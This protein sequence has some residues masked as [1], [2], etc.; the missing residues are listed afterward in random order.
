MRMPGTFYAF[1]ASDTVEAQSTDNQLIDAALAGDSRAF[2]Q[3]VQRYQ[4]RLLHTLAQM[5]DCEDDACD[6][7]QETFIQAYVKLASFERKSGFYTW[8]YRIGM[9]LAVSRRRRNRPVLSIDRMREES[10]IEPPDQG[11]APHARLDRQEAVDQVQAAIARLPDEFR[12]AL[13]LREIEG[14]DY[15]TI[16]EMLDIPVGTVRSRLHRARVQVRELLSTPAPLKA[17][18]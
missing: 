7:A 1:G 10:D 14:F 8:L 12:M 15:D 6:V 13:I 2:G 4:D 5:L 17:E 3:L 16:A 9:N 18:S 11:D